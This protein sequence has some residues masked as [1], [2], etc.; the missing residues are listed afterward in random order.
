[1]EDACNV[2]RTDPIIAG[3]CAAVQSVSLLGGCLNNIIIAQFSMCHVW[4]TGGDALKGFYC[5]QW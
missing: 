1:M 2:Y 3:R 5:H 4:I